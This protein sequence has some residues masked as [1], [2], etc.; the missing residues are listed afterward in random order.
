[1]EKG[2]RVTGKIDTKR[3]NLNDK[4]KKVKKVIS[5]IMGIII[6]IIICL[7]ANNYIVLDKNKKV[8]LVINNKNV[9]SNLKNDVLIEDDI[10]YLSQQD[11]SNFFDKHIYK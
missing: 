7:I 3:M 5:I 10:I 1:M 4:N 9:T 11:I 2:R 8:N 6:F